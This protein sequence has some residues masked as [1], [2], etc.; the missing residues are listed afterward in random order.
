MPQALC[1]VPS[2]AVLAYATGHLS[3]GQ[4]NPAVT[5][6]LVGVGALNPIQGFANLCAQVGHM[7]SAQRISA[8]LCFCRL[9]VKANVTTLYWAG[10]VGLYV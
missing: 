2:S 8:A 6:G 5:F 9:G 4:M 3:G 7:R 1:T 10:F